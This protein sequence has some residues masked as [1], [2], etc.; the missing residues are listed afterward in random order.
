MNSS[1]KSLVPSV[2]GGLPLPISVLEPDE[3]LDDEP[4]PEDELEVELELLPQAANASVANMAIAAS[5]VFLL[6]GP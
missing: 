6:R 3:E 1:V 4:D 5:M 2:I